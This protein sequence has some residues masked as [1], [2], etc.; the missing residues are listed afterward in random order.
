MRVRLLTVMKIVA[1]AGVFLGAYVHIGR[2]VETEHDSAFPL[3]LLEG[4]LLVVL[5]GI[6]WGF[7]SLVKFVE[8]DKEYAARLWR[9]DCRTSVSPGTWSTESPRDEVH[10][11]ED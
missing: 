1:I 4:E 7:R 8:K 11:T 10:R 2:V 5:L 6:A 3:L 9:S